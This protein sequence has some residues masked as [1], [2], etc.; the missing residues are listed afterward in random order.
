MSQATESNFFRQHKARSLNATQNGTAQWRIQPKSTQ[1]L[2][3]AVE[4]VKTDLEEGILGK[5]R[6][7]RK[8]Q[9]LDTLADRCYKNND[10]TY[11]QAMM[12]EQW[13]E[14]NDFKM[15]LLDSFVRDHMTKHLLNYEKCYS[16]AAFDA[17]PSN[18]DRDREFLA[19]HNKW[20]SNLKSNVALEL[21]V[22]ARDLF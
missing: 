2:M 13:Y 6:L 10:Y 3:D 8:Q 16:G 4:R 22:K 9:L 12:C 15:N 5:L 18:E 20:I 21:D 7:V 14:K 11:A 17:L 19:C 1:Q